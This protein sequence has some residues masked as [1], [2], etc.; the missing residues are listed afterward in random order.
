MSVS[1]AILTAAVE[2]LAET[3]Y[4]E[5]TVEAIAARAGVGKQTIY[6][7][8]P[9]RASLVAECML[10]G[11]IFEDRLA[12]PDTGDVRHDL[13]TWVADI[14]ATTGAPGNH[15]LLRSLILAAAEDEAVGQR[16]HDTLA[17][18]GSL[19]DRLAL[20]QTTGELPADAPLEAIGVAL[21]GAVVLRVLSRR[22][23]DAD[24]IARIVDVTVGRIARDASPA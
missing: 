8:W 18:D 12:L 5:L 16:L 3:G 20:A 19:T 9:S 10:E 14:V 6:R 24:A 7:W 2:L 21:L 13:R 23:T 22:E 1:S 11:R 17:A 4:N 15:G